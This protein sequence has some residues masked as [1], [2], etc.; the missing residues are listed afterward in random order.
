MNF[1]RW[2]L[3]SSENGQP[4]K[5][6]RQI[7]FIT[8]NGFWPLSKNPLTPHPRSQRTISS[9]MEC[10][11]KTQA[12]FTLYFKF[13][14][15]T[16]VKSYKINYQFFY[17][18]FYISF[19]INRYYFLQLF[20]THSTLLKKIFVAN[21]PFLTDSPKTSTPFN[22]QN[23]L[24]VTKVFCQFSLTCLL[25]FFIFKYLL[26]KSCKSIFYVF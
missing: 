11:W 25:I 7:T 26:A 24:I 19:G 6:P 13:W 8:L 10:Q 1:S 14:E 16:S 21:F 18:L 22:G 20:R 4:L 3:N 17:F 23:L 12:C 9:W 2:T 15:G 5:D